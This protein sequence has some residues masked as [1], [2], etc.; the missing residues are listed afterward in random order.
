MEEHYHGFELLLRQYIHARNGQLAIGSAS[1]Q[2][3]MARREWLNSEYGWRKPRGPGE[4]RTHFFHEP[5]TSTYV[6]SQMFTKECK[7]HELTPE[8]IRQEYLA[9]ARNAIQFLRGGKAQES[10]AKP[11]VRAMNLQDTL[12]HINDLRERMQSDRDILGS[13]YDPRSLNDILAEVDQG[14]APYMNS[15]K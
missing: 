11:Y 5:R 15:I 3:D 12:K 6:V 1:S 10:N 7:R 14:L 9:R 13:E 4:S 2:R 8:G